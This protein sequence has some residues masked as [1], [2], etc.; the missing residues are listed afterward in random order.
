[1]NSVFCA[2]QDWW[3]SPKWFEHSFCL[4]NGVYWTKVEGKNG[5]KIVTF[6]SPKNGKGNFDFGGMESS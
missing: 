2:I 5:L 6:K 3:L 4:K 1:M